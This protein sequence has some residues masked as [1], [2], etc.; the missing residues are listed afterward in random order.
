MEIL[1]LIWQDRLRIIII[2]TDGPFNHFN[3]RRKFST[4][5]LEN[6]ENVIEIR[7]Q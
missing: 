3:S 2:Y 6:Q 4:E 7:Q 1:F 5:N